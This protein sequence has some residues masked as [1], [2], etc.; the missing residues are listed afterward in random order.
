M[1]KLL[2][3]LLFGHTVIAV[4]A[5]EN[6]RIDSSVQKLNEVVITAQRQKQPN[7]LVPF[8]VSTMSRKEMDDYQFRTTPETLF[9]KQI[10]VVDPLL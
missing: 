1:K 8:S 6:T 9:K 4:A 10:M 7:L 2:L 5:Q 3:S